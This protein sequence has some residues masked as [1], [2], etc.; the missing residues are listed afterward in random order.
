MVLHQHRPNGL[1]LFSCTMYNIEIAVLRITKGLV[2]GYGFVCLV[3]SLD[4][5]D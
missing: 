5:Y 4:I 2:L 3:V 1:F